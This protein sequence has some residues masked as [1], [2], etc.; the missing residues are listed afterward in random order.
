M[1]TS[2][3]FGFLA[4]QQI[5]QSIID[6]YESLWINKNIIN[7]EQFSIED[8]FIL[9][10]KA[11]EIKRNIKSYF[12]PNNKIVG[13][14]FFEPSTRTS[15]SF[16]SAMYK[17]GGH[18]ITLNVDNSSFKKGESLEDTI[19][20]MEKYCDALVIRHPDNDVMQR[21][22]KVSTKPIINAGDGTHNHPTQALLDLYTIINK[23]DHQ[24]LTK[25]IITFVGDLKNGRTVHSLVKILALYDVKINYVSSP[26]LSIPN[27][28]IEYVSNAHPNNI[29][30]NYTEL[31]ETILNET[32][33]L[34]CTRIQKE[35]FNTIEEYNKVKNDFCITPTILSK[36]K[37]DAIIMHPLPRV[38]EIDPECDKDPRAYYFNQ[39]ECGIYIR[40]AL[41]SLLLKI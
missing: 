31:N 41:L 3:S 24:T 34:Y 20:T 17:L 15:C 4:N 40:M 39:V 36:C 13:I 2:K 8:L 21:I 14:L 10:N 12:K 37:E 9:F 5:S 1:F 27:D 11:G 28:I 7:A 33:I 35:R 29:Q 6:K 30:F 32:D 19:R 25:K 38:D 16:Q 22:L 23:Y 18:V 26:E